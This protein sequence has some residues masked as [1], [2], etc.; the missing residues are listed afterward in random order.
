MADL[1]RALP[2]LALTAAAA[3]AA[4]CGSDTGPEAAEQTSAAEDTTDPSEAVGS[5]PLTGALGFRPVLDSR[6][7]ADTE[8]DAADDDADL[9]DEIGLQPVDPDAQQRLLAGLRCADID[10]EADV[11][12]DLPLVTCDREGSV[13]YLLAP[14]IITEDGVA[15][16]EGDYI[17]DR[18][19]NIVQ[20][21]L[22]DQAAQVWSDYTREQALELGGDGRQVGITVGPVVASAPQIVGH[23]PVGSDTSITGDFTLDEA[24][25]LAETLTPR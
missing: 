23:T 7:A 3:L 10:L 11:D 2:A 6:E 12:P 18:G 14:A 15:G 1:R 24:R 25:Q 5:A 16:A 20:I 21:E 19:E 17:P 13:V 9:I 8:A 22:T 4:A